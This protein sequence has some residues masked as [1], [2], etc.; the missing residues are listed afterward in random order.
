MNDPFENP[1][2]IEL[3]STFMNDLNLSRKPEARMR[4][5]SLLALFLLAGLPATRVALAA[6]L[7][8]T[9]NPSAISWNEIGAKVGANYQGD[10]LAVTPD[11]FA[12]RLHCVF[13]RL[14]GEATPEGLWLTSTVTNTVSDRFRVT[15]VDVGRKAANA[16]FNSPLA[17]AGKVSVCG[18]TVRLSRPGLTEEYSV[19]MDGVRQD[20]IVEVSPGRGERCEPPISPFPNASSQPD[21]ELVVKLAVD[22]AKVETAA[23]GARLVLANSGRKIAYSRLRVTDATGKELPAR[24]EVSSV[25]DEATS[26]DSWC[27][28][29]KD[30]EELAIVVNDANAVYPVRID[31]TFSDANWVSMGG[32]T[33]V[34]GLVY[35]T[36]TDVSGNLYVG[37]H[38]TTAGSIAANYVAQWNGTDW[39][40]LG[41]GMGGGFPGYPEV[42]ALAVS[43]SNLYAGGQFTTA[44]GN[45]ATNIAQWNGTSWSPLGAGVNYDVYALAVSGSTLYAGGQF[46]I[47]GS[48]AA[49]GIAQWSGSTWSA[50]G[51]GIN[52]SVNALAVSGSRLYAGG[53]FTIAGGNEATNIAQWAG[54]SWSALGSGLNTQVNALA[55]LGGTLYAGGSF[56]TAGGSAANSIAQWNGN[57]WSALG[58]GMN[59][60]VNALAV[61][62]STLY[63]G[64][65]F[66]AAGGNV[67]SGVAQ[68]N[69]T[70]WSALGSEIK[71]N[72]VYALAVS[73]STLYAGGELY[74]GANYANNI[75]QWNGTNWSTLN[76][77]GISAVGANGY[78]P[79]VNAL[80]VLSNTVYAGG[81]FTLAGNIVANNIAQW[82]GTGWS[83]LGSGISG[84]NEI[85]PSVNALA[86]SGSALYVG[87]DFTNAGGIAANSIAQW[88][89]T[90]WSPLA[91]GISSGDEFGSLVNAL[92]VS[93]STL[94]VGGEF[95]N[96]GGIAAANIAQWNGTNWSSLGSGILGAGGEFGGPFV[97]ALALSGTTL[98]AGGSF[99]TAG[100][101]A[102]NFVAQWDG[103]SWSPLGSGVNGIVYALAL[104]NS[105]L[106]AGGSFT[107]AGGS[108]ANNIA[109]L[110]ASSWSPLGSGI[111]GYV[112][113]L[114]VSGSTLYAGG[115]FT[116]AGGNSANNIAQW[117]GSSWSPLGSGISGAGG[118][119]DGPYVNA[120]LVSGSTLYV[121][122]DFTTAGTNVSAYAAMA[123]LAGAPVSLAI[124]TTNTAFGFTNGV[125]GFDVSGPSGSSVVI[126]A[127]TD[128]QTWIPLQTNLLGSGPFYFSDSQSPAN[129]RR[130]YRAQ[131]SP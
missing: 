20:F 8:A 90:N 55:V 63:A 65:L 107:T 94:Y 22:G 42:L 92:A 21:G 70:N 30:N 27:V 129:V 24:I 64:G 56:S 88:N 97:Y 82:N 34:N 67:V 114:A 44:G 59:S 2:E 28:F 35:A 112:Y 6:D 85:G 103:S 50:L 15:A 127:S 7:A 108:A 51:S 80:A 77:G 53:Q 74:V 25:E 117:D 104:S 95:T 60:L 49:I 14:D 113:G 23:D 102:A 45:A 76:S 81:V 100:G 33:G 73:G 52:G 39:S 128:L 86:V 131:L 19:S 110:N 46:T 78:G 83:A 41:S 119:L 61:S 79:Y 101:S 26:L 109:Q 106:Y 130:F 121:G 69:G 111:N 96:A 58:S 123:N 87:G 40:A 1:D 13:Q 31:P 84:G 124:V 99:S 62:G 89:G 5:C 48:N 115:S 57:S 98:Y 38:F 91:S 43:G 122:G 66:T 29:D 10:G 9:N 93:G 125:F 4:P 118:D 17:E 16:A 75:A 37:G 120:L 126:Q 72:E 54:N 68:W 71:D 36:A 105:T 116:T 47:A 18:Q 32:L 3:K 11:G 12:A